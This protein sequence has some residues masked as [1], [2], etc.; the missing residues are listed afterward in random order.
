[1]CKFTDFFNVLTQRKPEWSEVNRSWHPEDNT[2]V[3]GNVQRRDRER[4]GEL[5][6]FSKHLPNPNI[7][8]IHPRGYHSE[9][10]RF[11]PCEA[12]RLLEIFTSVQRVYSEK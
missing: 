6:Q 12:H 10:D 5:V 1:M 4:L 9:C 11:F 3:I 2:N 7:C 8:C